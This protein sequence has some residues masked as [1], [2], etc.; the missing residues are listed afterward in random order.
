MIFASRVG[1]LGHQR[2]SRSVAVASAPSCVGLN[3]YVGVPAEVVH[4]KQGLRLSDDD[5][6]KLLHPCAAEKLDL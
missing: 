4:H 2:C 6:E 5:W 1:L 3:G